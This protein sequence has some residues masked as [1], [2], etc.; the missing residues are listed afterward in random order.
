M[1]KIALNLLLALAML[2]ALPFSAFA[3]EEVKDP[4][5]VAGEFKLIETENG[6]AGT[7]AYFEEFKLVEKDKN[8]VIAPNASIGGYGYINC[9]DGGAQIMVCDVGFKLTGKAQIKGVN[10]TVT[11]FDSNNT[12]WGT[13]PIDEWFSYGTL[14]S[15]FD[16]QIEEPLYKAG[17]YY[18]RVTGAVAGISAAD[19]EKI[20]AIVPV[21]SA[22]VTIK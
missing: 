13:E 18:A 7:A 19:G 9:H 17:T 20:Y 22:E 12:Q 5:N 1:K 10:A 16:T 8:G 6:H 15:K 4:Q 21:K 11:T 2:V 3:A 14:Y